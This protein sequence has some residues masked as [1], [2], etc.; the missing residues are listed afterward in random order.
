MLTNHQQEILD[1]SLSILSTN[2]RLS[3]IGSAGTGKTY[4]TDELINSLLFRKDNLKILVTAPTNKAVAVLK[5]KVTERNNQKFCT[6]HSALKMKRKIDHKTGKISFI[7]DKYA[8]ELPLENIDLLVVDESSMLNTSMLEYIEKYATINSTT[9]IFLGDNKQINPVGERVSLVFLG[10]RKK[11]NLSYENAIEYIEKDDSVNRYSVNINNKNKYDVYLN[12]PTVKLT[13]IV[14]QGKNNPIIDLSNNLSKIKNNIPCTVGDNGY[15]YS[16]DKQKVI[17]TLA[18]VNGTDEL[19][20]L[21]WTNNEVDTINK[22]VRNRIYKNP[23]KI[24][25][26]ETLVFNSPYESY[27]TSEEIKVDKLEEKIINFRYV[28]DE[29]GEINPVENKEPFYKYIDLKC[30]V[31]NSIHDEKDKKI[32]RVLVIHENSEKEYKRITK[33]LITK[34]RNSIISWADYYS[35]IEQFADLKYNHAITVH[36]SQ[37]STYRQVIINIGNLMLNKD[38]EERKRLLYTAVTRAKELLILYNT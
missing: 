16:N 38:L 25:K 17:D 34:A 13:E 20:Y 3:I 22:L 4:M 33:E 28:N 14:R 24:E 6:T 36:K 32:K 15:I 31:I 29:L 11:S 26:G 8:K 9:V 7:P 5:E 37:G 23:K 21:A 1:K 30:Y 27:F 19:K 35:F 18:Y 2:K 12:Y 10:I